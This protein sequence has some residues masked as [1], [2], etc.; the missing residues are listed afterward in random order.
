MY[1]VKELSNNYLFEKQNKKSIFEV[2]F[3][4]TGSYAGSNKTWLTYLHTLFCLSSKFGCSDIL[5]EIFKISHL[6][7]DV[8]FFF[9]VF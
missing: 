6:L 7:I 1:T 4:S 2:R 5:L 3:V 9:L 8:G